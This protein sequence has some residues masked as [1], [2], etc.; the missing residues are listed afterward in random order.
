MNTNKIFIKDYTIIA[1]HGYYK[2][3]HYKPQRFVVSVICNIKENQSG[4]S[5]DLKE[6][7]NY[8]NIRNIIDEVIKGEHNKLLESLTEKI[9]SK[10]LNHK[11]VMLVEVEITKPDIWG[12]CMPGVNIVRENSF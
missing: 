9:A 11:N 3:E 10:I 6:T 2:E 4:N 8:E 7:F 12:D 5:D 1:K